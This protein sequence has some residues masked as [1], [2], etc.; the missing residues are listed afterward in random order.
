MPSCASGCTGES[1]CAPTLFVVTFSK[2]F[3]VTCLVPAIAEWQLDV[4]FACLSVLTW[5]PLY[6]HVSRRPGPIDMSFSWSPCSGDTKKDQ[7]V[8]TPNHRSMRRRPAYDLLDRNDW[9]SASSH[10]LSFQRVPSAVWAIRTRLWA[11]PSGSSVFRRTRACN[12][13][14]SIANAHCCHTTPDNLVQH[15]ATT[16]S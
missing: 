1:T 15:L 4:L 10:L 3:F 12:P 2:M 5:W 14:S 8:L 9:R 6:V 16:P 11:F 13:P 7:H